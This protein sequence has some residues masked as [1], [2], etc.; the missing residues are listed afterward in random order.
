MKLDG[1]MIKSTVKKQSLKIAFK[2]VQRRRNFQAPNVG[3][4]LSSRSISE[5]FT[6]TSAWRQFG[7]DT[8]R[9][10]FENTV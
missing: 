9:G 2:I 4:V 5:T 8:N 7:V 6:N 3:K 10:G 1:I